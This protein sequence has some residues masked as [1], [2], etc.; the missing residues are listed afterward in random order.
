MTTEPDVLPPSPEGMT[1]HPLRDFLFQNRHLPG[2]Q[3]KVPTFKE[4]RTPCD[5]RKLPLPEAK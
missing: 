4:E 3:A 5:G 1:K 2:G